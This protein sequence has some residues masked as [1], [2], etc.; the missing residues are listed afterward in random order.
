MKAEYHLGA[1]FFQRLIFVDSGL[2]GIYIAA[3]IQKNIVN[4][5]GVKPFQDRF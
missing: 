2:Y 5:K 4:T 1:G 3:G